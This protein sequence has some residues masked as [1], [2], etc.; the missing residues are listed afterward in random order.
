MFD[1]IICL[2]IFLS[3]HRKKQNYKKETNVTSRGGGFISVFFAYAH[4]HIHVSTILYHKRIQ[5]M[6]RLEIY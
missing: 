6:W 4:I 3:A 1:N 2:P 5:H